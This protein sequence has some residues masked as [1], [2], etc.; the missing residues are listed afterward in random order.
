[1]LVHAVGVL[2]EKTAV[3]GAAV[4]RTHSTGVVNEAVE[5]ENC[6][7]SFFFALKSTIQG[8]SCFVLVNC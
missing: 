8:V 5:T 2:Q 6:N 7:C 4:A 1:M 3:L